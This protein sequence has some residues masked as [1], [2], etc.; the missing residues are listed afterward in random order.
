MPNPGWTGPSTWQGKY[1]VQSDTDFGTNTLR[2]RGATALD[3][4]VV[5]DD[6]SFT[7][8]LAEG[9]PSANNGVA[10]G[11]GSDFVKMT[12]TELQATLLP[13]DQGLNI[14][15]S[16]V[17]PLGSYQRINGPP[18]TQNNYTDGGLAA[19]TT[20]YYIIDVVDVNGDSFQLTSPIAA[21]TAGVPPTPTPTPTPGP[22]SATIFVR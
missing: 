15:R 12:L 10:V 11:T 6:T 17:E 1:W 2:V 4:W 20:Y 5:P 18:V 22:V 19:A 16:D 14:R 8:A 21:T 7:I 9:K 3:G 13:D